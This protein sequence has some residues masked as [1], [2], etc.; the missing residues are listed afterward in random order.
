MYV[1]AKKFKTLQ[2]QLDR[3]VKDIN[4]YKEKKWKPFP[5]ILEANVDHDKAMLQLGMR[6]GSMDIDPKNIATYPNFETRF[7]HQ[8]HAFWLN[9][10]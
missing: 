8:G 3:C 7:L 10:A 4:E 1:Y 5:D 2:N 6:K 9:E